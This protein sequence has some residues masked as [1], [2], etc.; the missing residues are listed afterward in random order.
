ML[1]MN[2][3]SNVTLIVDNR[4]PYYAPNLLTVKCIYFNVISWIILD[5]IDFKDLFSSTGM[6]KYSLGRLKAISFIIGIFVPKIIYA[7]I[8]HIKGKSITFYCLF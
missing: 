7:R 1:Y 3:S 4:S 2:N 6:I 5:F 8:K